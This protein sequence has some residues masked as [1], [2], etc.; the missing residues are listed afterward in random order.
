MEESLTRTLTETGEGN[1]V[2]DVSTVKRR[3]SRQSLGESSNTENTTILPKKCI[4]CMK[5]KY[6]KNSRNREKLSSCLQFRAD[7]S[8]RKLATKRNDSNIIAVATNDM[9]AKEACYH[10]TCYRDYTR[11]YIHTSTPNQD[12]NVTDDGTSDVIK[13]LITLHELP[14]IVDFRKL[15][16]MVTSASGKKSLKRNIESK[17]KDFKFINHGKEI[18]VYPVSWKV[19]DLV[20]CLHEAR[21]HLT[22][23]EKLN[24]EEKTVLGSANIIREE[25]KNMK[26]K[27]S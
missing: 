8:I 15:Q 9:I 22:K 14:D 25:I 20:I 5:D 13:F 10:F 23:I 27:M 3:S 12:T 11:P 4:F 26:Y 6:V 24:S 16:N 19:E 1:H 18:L 7:E 17:T 2:E 21:T